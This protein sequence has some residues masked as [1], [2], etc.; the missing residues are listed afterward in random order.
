MREISFGT[1]GWRG[2]LAGDFTFDN[3]ELVAGAVADYIHARGQAGQGV[4]K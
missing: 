2:I 3:V 4:E 1:D